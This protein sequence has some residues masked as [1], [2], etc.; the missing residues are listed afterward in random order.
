[1]QKKIDVDA[2]GADTSPLTPFVDSS[3]GDIGPVED[4]GYTDP[5][6][7]DPDNDLLDEEDRDRVMRMPEGID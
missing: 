6:G 7:D 3:S 1:M 5:L 4:D 2:P